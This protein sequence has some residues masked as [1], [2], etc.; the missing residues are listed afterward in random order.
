MINIIETI[1]FSEP[2]SAID[3]KLKLAQKETFEHNDRIIIE[4][5]VNDG[6]PFIDSSGAKLIEIQKLINQ[7][8]IPNYVILLVTPNTDIKSEI[9]FITK[10]YAADATPISFL[11]VDGKYEKEIAKYSNTSCKKLWNHLNI[12]TDGNI[13][14]CCLADHKFPLGNI[15]GSDSIEDIINSK[16]SNLVRQWMKEGYRP[17]ACQ[18][19]YIREDNDLPSGRIAF[20]DVDQEVNITTLDIRINNICNFKCRMCSEYF[21]S[22]IQKETITLRSK[23]ALPGHEQNLLVSNSLTERRRQLDA[24]IPYV[25]NN[26]EYIYFAGGEPLITNEH[27]KILDKLID[28]NH[29][30]LQLRY[31]T[32]LSTLIYKNNNIIDYWNQFSNVEVNASIDASD[33]V[34]EYVR[35]GTVW[36]DIVENIN[37]IKKQAPSVKLKIA[38]TVSFLTIENLINLQNRWIDEKLFEITDLS[39]N[40]LITPNYLSPAVLP[41]H[42][43]DRLSNSISKHINR[44]GETKIAKQWQEVLSYMMNNDYTH[45]LSEFT[46]RTRL[47]D[48]HRKESFNNVFPEFHDLTSQ[49][50]KANR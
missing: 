30:K 2:L 16:K 47:L 7:T 5:D 6:Y 9:E 15:N 43:K 12:G 3:Q 42:H 14:P 34:A 32:N 37:K 31:N 33:A 40:V 20:K 11:I 46:Q 48:I 13:N 8:N 17:V 39:L 1:L 22:A 23:D 4:Q 28:I 41:R 21:S 25:N 36:I 26:I 49:I 27:Y 24:I 50:I 29:T 19:C 44:L 18:P 35:H 45:T 38:S 10:F